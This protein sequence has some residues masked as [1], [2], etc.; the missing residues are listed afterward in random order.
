[1]FALQNKHYNF[2]TELVKGVLDLLA[3]SNILF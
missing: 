1:M 2:D 3:A